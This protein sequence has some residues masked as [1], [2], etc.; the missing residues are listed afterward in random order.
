MTSRYDGVP[1]L[2]L[3]V[4]AL[5]GLAMAGFGLVA[6]RL[7]FGRQPGFG[8]GQASILVIGAVLVLT[9]LCL[10]RFG[11]TRLGRG[12]AS[13]WQDSTAMPRTSRREAWPTVEEIVLTAVLA[14]LITAL[15][16]YFSRELGLLAHPPGYD[17]ISYVLDAKSAFYHLGQGSVSQLTNIRVPLWHAL[18]LLN[19]LILGEGEWQA[20]A[21]RFWPT[22]LFLLLVMWVVRRRAGT[23]VAWAAVLFTA[24]L[25]TISV[26]VRS[27]AWEYFIGTVNFGPGWYLADLRPDLLFAVLLLWAVAPLVENVHSLD[28]VTWLVSG[29]FAALAVFS[30][31]SGSP[32]LL[33]AWGL[34]ILYALAVNR[35]R[36]K[37][38]I[39]SGLWGAFAFAVLVVPWAL[40]GGAPWVVQHL[41]FMQVLSRHV[42]GNPQATVLSETTHYWR[43][44]PF[45]MGRAEGWIVLGVGLVSAAIALKK[46]QRD[47]RVW[48]YAGLAVALYLGVCV[49][50]SKNA[51]NGLP[52]Y[53][54]L[55]VFGWTAFAL[56]LPALASH[57]RRIPYVLLVVSCLY[58]AGWIAGSFYALQNWTDEGRVA[59]AK[60]R[61]AVLQ[62]AGDLKELLGPGDCF[63]AGAPAFGFPATLQYYIV[64][65]EETRPTSKYME[66][67]PPSDTAPQDPREQLGDCKAIL[68]FK[69]DLEEV[70]KLMWVPLSRR[71]LLR[72]AAEWVRGPNSGYELTRGYPIIYGD[73]FITIQLYVRRRDI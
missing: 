58:V 18:I 8:P 26:G 73:D 23:R 15:D 33:L 65:A 31:A 16:L 47:T 62:I 48:A 5:V 6:D 44:F 69:E 63:G 41:Y 51:F 28:W 4:L 12:L 20:Y 45:H 38:T 50:P 68:V 61:E 10:L 3:I 39:L 13:L 2:G 36:L 46:G 30:K 24:L 14:L 59:G 35:R 55:W 19:F 9:S 37:L 21:V 70:A 72:A 11:R 57:H 43:W 22:F 34:T 54:M 7:G 42:Y 17:G 27:S 67:R 29:T 53:L 66:D 1:K 49:T 32:G 56:I 52:Y 25:P 71:P 40:A 60:N 64:D